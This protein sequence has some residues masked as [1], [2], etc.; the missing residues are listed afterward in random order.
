MA[1]TTTSGMRLI[2]CLSMFIAVHTAHQWK[3][4]HSARSMTARW[5]SCFSN[6]TK[7]NHLDFALETSD[8]VVPNTPM[9]SRWTF[10]LL[11]RAIKRTSYLA[12]WIC[13][14]RCTSDKCG[15]E[16]RG[17]RTTSLDRPLTFRVHTSEMSSREFRFQYKFAYAVFGLH[18]DCIFH[19]RAL[20]SFVLW[21]TGEIESCHSI[22]LENRNW[23]WWFAVA[24]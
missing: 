1:S 7:G 23:N 9:K 13:L 22:T 20:R 2:S 19:L 21:R 17:T 4:L 18:L 11:L 14:L 5:Y 10:F 8:F 6:K 24:G 12:N 3:L 15:A 16:K